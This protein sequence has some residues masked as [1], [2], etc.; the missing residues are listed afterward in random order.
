MTAITCGSK[1]MMAVKLT[2]SL[3]PDALLLT[4]RQAAAAL[5]ISERTLWSITGPRGP[6]PAVKIGRAVRYCPTDLHVW[7][8]SQKQKGATL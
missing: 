6:L 3:P 4:S 7:I 8:E 2:P 5:S 1:T